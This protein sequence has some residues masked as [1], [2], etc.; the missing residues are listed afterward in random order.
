MAGLG[1]KA[2]EFTPVG[3]LDGDI[4]PHGVLNA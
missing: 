4:W 3:L 2:V 1:D